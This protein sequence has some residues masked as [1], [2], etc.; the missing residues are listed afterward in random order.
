MAITPEPPLITFESAISHATPRVPAAAPH[1]TAGE[2]WARL[3]GQS[4]DCA[5]HIVVFDAERF[6]GVVR[7][8]ALLAAA[9]DETVEALMDADPPSVEPGAD[10]ELAAWHAVRNGESALAVLD[11]GGRYHGLIPPDRLLAVLLTEHEEDISRFGGFT[12]GV[13]EVRGTAEEPV[14]RR[15]RHRIPWLLLGLA[16]A[17]LAA[18]FVSW[19]EAQ[20]HAQVMLAFF[21]PGIVY[22]ADAVG[23]QT[24]TVV[25]RGLSLGV[26]MRRMLAREVATGLAIGLVLAATAGPLVWWRWGDVR[27]AACLFVAVLAACSSATFAA[28]GIPWALSAL[29]LDPAFG[30]GPLATVVQD[31]TTIL[32]YF[33]VAA[34]LVA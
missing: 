10:Q 13:V 31:L 8:E 29:G 1:D 30:S 18:D 34:M 33:A 26:P 28:M 17:L 24:E 15:F 32:I 12:K 9:P 2:V 22:L 5:S 27:V 20:I 7:I 3:R 11:A 6:C 25:V 21:L 16:G 19:F 4:F 14:S 23:T